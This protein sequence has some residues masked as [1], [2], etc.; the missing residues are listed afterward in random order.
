MTN[1]FRRDSLNV[2]VVLLDTLRADHLSCYGAARRTSPNIDRIASQATLFEKA[3]SPAAWTPPAHASLFTGTYPSRHHVDRSNL[4]LGSDLQPLPE[5]LRRGGYRTYG[6]SSNYWLSRETSFDRG[7]DEFVHSWQ[8]VQTAGTNAPLARQQRKQDLGLGDLGGPAETPSKYAQQ[9][10]RLFEKATNKLRN[11]LQAYD[12]GAY[13]VV[14]QVKRWI[15]RWVREEQPFFAF[16]HFMEPHIRYSAPGQ[17][18]LKHIPKGVSAERARQVNQDPWRFLTGQTEMTEEDFVILSA[19]Y[20]GE[21]SYLDARIGQLHAMLERSGL[22]ENTVVIFTSDHGENLGEHGLMDHA[23]CLYDTLLN[24]PLIIQAPSE[25]SAGERI[26]RPVQSADLFGTILTL[27]GMDEDPVW[28]QVQ[29]RNS[30]LPAEVAKL[31]GAERCT[32]A[33]YREP[34]PPL[35]VLRRRFEGFNGAYF[36]RSLRMARTETHKFI[37]SSDGHAEL[38]DLKKDPREE[39]NLVNIERDTAERLGR[40]IDDKLGTFEAPDS[41]DTGIDLDD[42]TLKKLEQL[43]YLA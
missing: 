8:L 32:L 2:I 11:R 3:I 19:L 26:S 1:H 33:E 36:D 38:Y 5:V 21:I 37:W 31:N 16:L 29:A 30:L 27:A 14:N 40:V 7:F 4:T 41:A 12:D 25:F 24:V 23:Y 43:G 9:A 18:H 34:Q 15:P 39:Q 10:N 35:A 22:L 17:Y 28:D 13:R 20:D 6:V 42:D